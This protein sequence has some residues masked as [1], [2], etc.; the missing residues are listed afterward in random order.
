[1]RDY[2]LFADGCSNLVKEDRER[3]G[4]KLIPMHIF[5]DDVKYDTTPDYE[6]MDSKAFY[7]RVR[8]GDRIYTSMVLPE[9]FEANFEE[10]LKTGKDILYIGCA[11]K[12]SAAVRSAEEAKDNLLKKYPDAKIEII[13]SKNATYALGMAI[14]DAAIRKN[15]G[16][17]IEDNAKTAIDTLL[18]YNEI[19]Y[20]DKLVYLKR[21]GR[22]SAPS[23]FFGGLLGIKPI[24]VSDKEGG[25]AAI[26]KAKGKNKAFLR[27]IELLKE[28]MDLSHTTVYMNHADCLIEAK[29]F[30][31]LINE[32]ISDKLEFI[33]HDIEPTIGCC[34]GPGT[35][36]FNFYAKK[37]MRNLAD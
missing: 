24:I 11:L 30:A 7:D 19:G 13:D 33:Y 17:S 36:I 29:E 37:E 31:K 6:F 28:Y 34:V 3:L 27:M 4:I 5:I 1:M 18:N 14:I 35:I 10:V 21:A 32:K 25:N 20:V 12:L 26:E 22:V 2:V 9:E 23:A 16:M 15:E 8:N